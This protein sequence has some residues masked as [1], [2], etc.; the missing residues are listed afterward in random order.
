LLPRILALD[1]SVLIITGDHS[2]PCAMK[3]HS[4]HP[5]PVLF[6]SKLS[7]P[8]GID[9]FGERACLTGGL[10]SRFPAYELMPLALAHANR[11]EKFGA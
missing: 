9:S 11:L 2:T 6:Y 7:R 8:D 4:W 1:P 5:V 3:Y 10:G